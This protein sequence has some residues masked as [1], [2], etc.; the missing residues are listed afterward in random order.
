MQCVCVCVCLLWLGGVAP[1]STWPLCVVCG[2]GMPCDAKD[3]HT[4]HNTTHTAHTQHSRPHTHTRHRL[5]RC[6]TAPLSG[7]WATR[8]TAQPWTCGAWDASWRSSCWVRGC[9]WRCV[10]L[11]LRPVRACPGPARTGRVCVCVCVCVCV[12]PVLCMHGRPRRCPHSDSAELLLLLLLHAQT[13][14]W[15]HRRAP[16]PGQG[17]D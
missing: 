2:C 5:S 9:A 10:W 16:V 7:C 6:G 14:M 17:R 11:G 8:A 3:R 15:M 4:F 13:R 12:A 1:A